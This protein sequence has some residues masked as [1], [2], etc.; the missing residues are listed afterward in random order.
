MKKFVLACFLLTVVSLWGCKSTDGENAQIIKYDSNCAV[1]KQTK[2]ERLASD[3]QE[4]LVSTSPPRYPI[5]AVLNKIEGYTR[6]E[7]DIA[8]NGKP[9]NIKVI[10][11]FPS[12]IFNT[13]AIQALSGWRFKKANIK[14]RVVQLDFKLG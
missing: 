4:F 13:V 14:C 7:F 8:Q 6:L 9:V 3:F 5:D 11:A 2:E 10:E 1:H 12:D